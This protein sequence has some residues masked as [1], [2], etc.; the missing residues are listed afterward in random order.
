VKAH[1][2]PPKTRKPETLLYFSDEGRRRKRAE[3]EITDS[4]QTNP[5][6]YTALLKT[7]LL[8]SLS[9]SSTHSWVVALAE[10]QE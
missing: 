8:T 5:L 1:H 4:N 2:P 10:T 9:F 3:K 6:P 7:V